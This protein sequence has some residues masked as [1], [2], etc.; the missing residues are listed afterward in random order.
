MTSALQ[1]RH[2]DSVASLEN[3]LGASSSHSVQNDDE[4]LAA[5][6]STLISHPR[7]TRAT[8]ISISNN[9]GDP[10]P[11]A[12]TSLQITESPL[13]T[14]AHHSKQNDGQGGFDTGSSSSPSTRVS[15][16]RMAI[17]NGDSEPVTTNPIQQELNPRQVRQSDGIV[18]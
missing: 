5:P 3:S 15:S 16:N 10:K 1:A 18:V 6:R 12:Q 9:N 8:S 4:I 7:A 2:G 14:S 17:M 13:T 11:D